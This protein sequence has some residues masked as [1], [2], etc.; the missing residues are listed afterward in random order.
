MKVSRKNALKS[1]FG[2]L[3]GLPALAKSDDKKDL[4]GFKDEFSAAWKSSLD[5][6][7]KIFT[8]MPEDKFGRLYT[9][10]DKV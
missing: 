1:L 10:W 9:T 7:L 3:I 4:L 6:T 8:Q 5:Y 2:T